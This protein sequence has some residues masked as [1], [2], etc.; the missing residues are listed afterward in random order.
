VLS[1]P[2]TGRAPKSAPLRSTRFIRGLWVWTLASTTLVAALNLGP[3]RPAA[4]A[5]VLM[6]SGL[7]LVWVVTG[8][9]LMRRHRQYVQARM[10]ALPGPWQV[11]FVL[12]CT[13]LALLEEAVTTTMTNLAP[14]FGVPVGRAYITASANYLDVVCF[15]S[16]VVFVPMFVAWAWMLARWD[17]HPNAVFLAFG[18]T[19]TL[20]EVSFGGPQQ[21][22]AYGMWT[23][24]YGLMIYLPALCVPPDRGARPPRWWHHVLAV[25]VPFLFLPLFAPVLYPILR[26]HPEKVHFPPIPPGA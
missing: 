8:G 6:G 9:L 21:F 14:V 22:L 15:H 23:F 3:E 19:G 18:A 13:L 16:V 11:K 10:R 5:V 25:L 4:R 24:V 1:A 17:F 26:W 2:Q 12:F 7:V 20:A